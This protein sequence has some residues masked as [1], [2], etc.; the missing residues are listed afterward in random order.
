VGADNWNLVKQ[1]ADKRLLVTGRD[2]ATN[3]ETVEIVHEA[4]IQEW[5]RLR[6]WLDENREFLIRARNIEASAQEWKE[7]KKPRTLAY[8]LQGQRL[9]EAKNLLQTDSVVNLSSLAQEFIKE[10][11]KAR[12]AA[13]VRTGLAIIVPLGAS[14]ISAVVIWQQT[15]Q[16]RIIQ[17]REAALLGTGNPELLKILPDAL[18][19]ADRYRETGDVEQAIASYRMTLTATGSVRKAI[20]QKPKEFQ[21]Q[22]AQKVKQIWEQAETSLV[23]MIQKYQIPNLESELKNGQFGKLK[24]DPNLKYTQFEAQYTEGALRTTYAILL[25]DFGVKAGTG[26]RRNLNSN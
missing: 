18:Q 14:V 26:A 2:K 9:V 17:L 12:K 16:Q 24:E 10:S 19:Q 5:E 4:L 1:L 20:A 7:K 22:E 21:T 13:Q 6:Q 15:V 25:R 3:E 23:E 8:L 11:Q